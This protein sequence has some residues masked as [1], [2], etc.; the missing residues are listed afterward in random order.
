AS[1]SR[2]R[3]HLAGA[4]LLVDRRERRGEA[5]DAGARL[6][7]RGSD[8]GRVQDRREERRVTARARSTARDLRGD[9][10]ETHVD[11]RRSPRLRLLRDR[12]RRVA[13]GENEPRTPPPG[14]PLASAQ[15]R[16]VTS[17]TK[18]VS[19]SVTSIRWGT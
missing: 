9:L 15:C 8:A 19:A 16:A 12:R 7:T 4:N 3:Q 6:R 17:S 14:P 1:G 5:P 13:R 10:P 2:G 18:S 11:P